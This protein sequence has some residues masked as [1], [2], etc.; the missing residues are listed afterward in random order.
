[1]VLYCFLLCLVQRSSQIN[2]NR[3]QLQRSFSDLLPQEDTIGY[4]SILLDNIL[5]NSMRNMNTPKGESCIPRVITL[6]NNYTPAISE[7]PF[8]NCPYCCSI[9]NPANHIGLYFTNKQK[10]NTFTR[11]ETLKIRGAF[12]LAGFK[13]DLF[14]IIYIHGF[15]GVGKGPSGKRILEA[16]LS[17]TEN[18]NIILVDWKNLS[19]GPWYNQAATNTRIAGSTLADILEF[20]NKTGEID[21][22]KVHLI[23]MSLGA[24]VAGFTGKHFNGRHKIGRITGLDPAFPLFPLTDTSQRLSKFD[25]DFVDVIHTNGG[26]LRFPT[27][28]G[29]A[30]FYP[31]GGGTVQ[32]GCD[33]STLAE[34]K[35]MNIAAFCSHYMA[36]EFYVESVRKPTAFPI[37][38][39][40]DMHNGYFENCIIMINGFMGFLA[41]KSLLGDFYLTSNGSWFIKSIKKKHVKR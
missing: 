19:A 21:L 17:R 26:I 37:S 38:R 11:L 5:S 34:N 18:Y 6:G 31:N 41:N 20:Y 16:Y 14:T 3:F 39:C 32:P 7:R 28:L 1:M 30:D 13:K 10:R 24:H 2:N 9:G 22:S 12:K 27:S 25:A 33:L 36:F 15:T 29:H 23:D 40:K 4:F 35:L 8:G